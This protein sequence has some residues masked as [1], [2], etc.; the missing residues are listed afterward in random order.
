MARGC[1]GGLESKPRS[2]LDGA[3]SNVDGKI[4]GAAL[5]RRPISPA[6]AVQ[7]QCIT[8][9]L[10]DLHCIAFSTARVAQVAPRMPSPPWFAR[11]TFDEIIIF[12]R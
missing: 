10:S 6:G 3:I 1:S 2:H 11:H 4:D 5:G 7:T 8:P 9:P 12:R